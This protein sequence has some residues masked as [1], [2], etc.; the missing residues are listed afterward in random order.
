[1][2]LLLFVLSELNSLVIRW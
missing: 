2:E 1:M